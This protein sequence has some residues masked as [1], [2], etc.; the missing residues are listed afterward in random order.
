MER[1]NSFLGKHL[2][3]QV[4][5]SLLVACVVALLLFPRGSAASTLLYVAFSSIGG[6]GV[7]LAVRR[8]EKRA[9]GGSVDGLVALD[10]KLRR[11]EV[12][13]A[14]EERRAMRDLVENRLHRGRHR[15]AAQIGLAVLSCAVVVATAL[16]A[17]LPRTLGIALFTGAFLGWLV[18]Y[19]NRQYRRLR[20]MHA[21]LTA[22]AAG[23]TEA[24]GATG[25]AGAAGA[26]GSTGPAEVPRATGETAR[27]TRETARDARETARDPRR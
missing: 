16:T 2:W 19:G 27:D 26:A 23:A 8:R 9:A 6:L 10:R 15:V 25:A 22:G 5:L 17:N 24:A 21:E 1:V 12:P 4:V 7:V 18:L 3:V 13:T 14:P 11:G 20:A